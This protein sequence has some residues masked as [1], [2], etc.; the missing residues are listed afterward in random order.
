[1]VALYHFYHQSLAFL[2]VLDK[3]KDLEEKRI[4]VIARQ[5][6]KKW[7]QEKSVVTIPRVPALHVLLDKFDKS[8]DFRRFDVFL[9]QL[10]VVVK[11]GRDGDLSPEEQLRVVVMPPHPDSSEWTFP[12]DENTVT[13]AIR[14]NEHPQGIWLHASKTLLGRQLERLVQHQVGRASTVKLTFKK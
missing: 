11:E 10:P 14:T 9:Q 3:T 1:M 2:F 7:C 13:V 6:N 12:E 5:K 4:T 8:L